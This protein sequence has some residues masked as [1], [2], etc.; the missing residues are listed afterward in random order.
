MTCMI[1]I[2]YLSKLNKRLPYY[3]HI[4]SLRI[5]IL[6]GQTN[7]LRKYNSTGGKVEL[8]REIQYSASV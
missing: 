7:L 8:R 1:F 5:S 4:T 6:F 2:F 3:D